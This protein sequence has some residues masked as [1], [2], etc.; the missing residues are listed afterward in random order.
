V[1]QTIVDAGL[2][3]YYRFREAPG[4]NPQDLVP[5]ELLALRAYDAHEVQRDFLRREDSG[6]SNILLVIEGMTCAA[7]A[8]LIERKLRDLEGVEAVSVNPSTRRACVVWDLET[9]PLSELLAEISRIGYRAH[10]Y[11]PDTQERVANETSRQALRRLGVAGLGLMQVMMFAVGL[12]AGAFEG[13]EAA[14]LHFL[15]WTSLLVTTPIVFY[16][17]QPFFF[18]AWRN[19]RAAQFGMDVPVAVAISGAYL[20]SVWATLQRSGEVYFDSVCMFVFLL[21]AVRYIELRIRQR[22]DFATHTM[23]RLFPHTATRLSEDR[24]EI[25]PVRALIRKDLVLVRPGETLPAD[26]IVVEGT[27]SVDES[28]LTG[29]PAPKAK[30]R[31]DPVIGGTRNVESPLFVE[32]T[33]TGAQTVLSTIVALLHRAQSE[34]PPLAG[35]TEKVASGFVA[36]V[37]VIAVGTYLFWSFHAPKDAFWIAL[38]VLVAT[39]P[40]ALSL[41]T[42]AAFAGATS[43]LARRGFLITRGHVL[44]ALASATHFLFDKTGT[45]TQGQLFLTEVRTVSE[46]SEAQVYALA[47]RLESASEH[48]VAGAFRGDSGQISALPESGVLARP[49][50]GMEGCVD[51]VCYRIGK[52]SF[53]A[54]LWGGDSVELPE[55]SGT[56]ILLGSPQGPLAW[57][58]LRDRLRPDAAAVIA[59]LR[60]QKLNVQLLSG[61][62]SSAVGEVAKAVGIETAYSGRTPEEKLGLVRG[63][64][65]S[66]AIVAMVGDGVNDAPVL[67]AAHLSIAMGGGTDLAKVSAD[68]VLLGDDLTVLKDAWY[69]ARKTRRI[70]RENVAWAIGYNL[71]VLPLAVCGYLTPLFAALGMSASS[72][73]VTLNALRL[74][75]VRRVG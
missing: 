40:C 35:L 57:F 44:Q 66:G 26:G 9:V 43:G 51:G 13:I 72:L 41:A 37:L 8:W 49:N 53:V 59:F 15:R 32:V 75:R 27:S 73:L 50:A 62:P 63:L 30:T 54:K 16:S 18:G 28:T 58:G 60:A 38:S 22:S 74:C 12:Y 19:L 47:Q 3:D 36:C 42:P 52:P 56:W 70:V 68:A 5:M 20:A 64:K 39:C 24:E 14:Y 4:R 33:E 71:A 69:W 65:E 31:G 46:F 21:L 61:D 2:V 29:E 25:V 17:A 67:G 48:P 7:C 11:S 6:K 10:P 55:E 45:L 34:K 1:A 23:L